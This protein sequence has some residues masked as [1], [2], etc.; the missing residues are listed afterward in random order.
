MP[1]TA[2]S[3]DQVGKALDAQIVALQALIAAQPAGS[4]HAKAFAGQLEVLQR[5]VVSYYVLRGRISAALILS[6][7]S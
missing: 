2:S 6:T 5:Q 1:V 4:Q 3:G 7:L